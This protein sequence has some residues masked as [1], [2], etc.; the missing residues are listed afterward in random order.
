LKG[1]EILARTAMGGVTVRLLQLNRRERVRE[2]E[3]MIQAGL[4]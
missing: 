3:M 1:G 2:R 4:L